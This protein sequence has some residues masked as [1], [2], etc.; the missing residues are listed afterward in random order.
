MHKKVQKKGEKSTKNT[1]LSFIGLKTVQTKPL[2][3][4]PVVRFYFL[5]GYFL[6]VKLSAVIANIVSGIVLVGQAGGWAGNVV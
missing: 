3:Y 1:I 6:C 5:L 2:A 4:L